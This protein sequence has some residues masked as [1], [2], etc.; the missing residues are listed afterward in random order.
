MGRR[1]PNKGGDKKDR[2]AEDKPVDLEELNVGKKN[3]KNVNKT[4]GVNECVFSSPPQPSS[5]TFLHVFF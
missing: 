3:E 1:R 2:R 5:P 4:H